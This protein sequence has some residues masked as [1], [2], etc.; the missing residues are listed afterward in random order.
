MA[1]AKDTPYVVKVS[2]PKQ[3]AAKESRRDDAG[4][5]CDV[6][7]KQPKSGSRRQKR[8]YHKRRQYEYEQSERD[9][10]EEEY[11][12]EDDDSDDANDGI[13]EE[14]VCRRQDS[15]GRYARHHGAE[16]QPR[17]RKRSHYD[18]HHHSY[19]NHIEE[20]MDAAYRNEELH[21]MLAHSNNLLRMY[22]RKE[23]KRACS[24]RPYH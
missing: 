11:D 9:Y 22:D 2:E 16:M 23:L 20:A 21:A 24:R 1:A 18:R 5:Q 10:D 19:S 15:S 17:E 7:E 14:T 4:Q 6:S 3:H 8:R 13:D 12:E